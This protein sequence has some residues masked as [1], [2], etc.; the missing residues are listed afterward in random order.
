[1][2]SVDSPPNHSGGEP[3]HRLVRELA[4]IARATTATG[5]GSE[6][7][8]RTAPGLP[9]TGH[10]WVTAEVATTDAMH[11]VTSLTVP[12]AS[13]SAAGPPPDVASVVR[14]VVCAYLD[15]AGFKEGRAHATVEV[16]DGEAEVVRC[17]LEGPDGLPDT[18]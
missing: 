6:P 14:A 16:S 15:L 13:G 8:G 18:P 1:M 11:R 3:D 4:D 17:R 9:A 10:L 2:N 7:T 12:G 5:D